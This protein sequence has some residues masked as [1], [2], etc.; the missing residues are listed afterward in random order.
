MQSVCKST[1]GGVT[2]TKTRIYSALNFGIRGEI[3][4]TLIR[5]ASFPSMSVDRSVALITVIYIL[6][7]LK[8][9]LHLQVQI[10]ILL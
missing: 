3:K 5:V 8:E 2:W 9:V 1:D 6:P 7:G 10:L 4:P